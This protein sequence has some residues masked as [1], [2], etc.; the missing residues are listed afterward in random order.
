MAQNDQN[1]PAGLGIPSASTPNVPNAP[2]GA[3]V[4]N[5]PNPTPA[6]AAAPAA[7]MLTY[8][9]YQAQFTAQQPQVAPGQMPPAMVQ[10][11]NPMLTTLQ[12]PP[13]PGA[14]PAPVPAP[15]PVLPAPPVVPEPPKEA[16]AAEGTVSGL[17]GDMANDPALAP[18]IAYLEAAATTA[19]LDV[20]RAFG[21]AADELDPRFIDRAYLVEKVGQAQADQ[22]IK[23]AESTIVY[24]K[25]ATEKLYTDV[26]ASAGGDEVWSQAIE[27][28]N[29]HAPVETKRAIGALFDTMDAGQMKYAAAQVVAFAKQTG[30]A[31]LPTAQPLGT[32]GAVQGLS[33]EQYRAELAKLPRNAPD[34]AY[35]N[36]RNQ[37]Q[38]GQNAGLK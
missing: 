38:A 1:L 37:R 7:P 12:A 24:A 29:Q 28:F 20:T 17:A 23:V 2:S 21:Q 27:L 22:M 36:L 33:Q 10:N 25:A 16:P 30:G 35:E 19:G 9:Q 3:S 18:G 34:S 5:M 4:I 31:V 11:Q 6:P 26:R 32:P 13:A 15:A 14:V 8:E